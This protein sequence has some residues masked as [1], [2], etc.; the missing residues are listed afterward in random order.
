MRAGPPRAAGCS[1]RRDHPAPRPAY[2]LVVHG[3]AGALPR[4]LEPDARAACV[5]SLAG[6]L[7][8]GCRALDEGSSSLD[9]VERTVRALEDDPLFD[10]GRGAVMT[11]DG[12]HELD[13]SIMD[14]RDRSC[15]AV[16]GARTVPRDPQ[17]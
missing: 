7:R 4:D 16:A 5:A 6:A 13:A 2:A 10:A 8:A 15:G 11:A 9:V 12:R 3:G 1:G 14:G 17:T